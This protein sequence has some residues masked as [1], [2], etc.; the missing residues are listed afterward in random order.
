MFYKHS[1][2]AGKQQFLTYYFI[3]AHPGCTEKE[4]KE[5]KVFASEKL[6]INPEQ[7]Q[8]FTPTPSTYSTLMYYTEKNPWTGEKIFIEKDTKRK[9]HQKD[10]VVEKI[11]INKKRNKPPRK[12]F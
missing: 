1:H 9:Q 11:R 6:K 10:L 3:A 8:I 2:E 12:R 5:L 7:V 4:M